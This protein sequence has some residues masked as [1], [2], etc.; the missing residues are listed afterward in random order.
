MMQSRQIVKHE[1]HDT[2]TFHSMNTIFFIQLPVE[3]MRKYSTMLVE[4]LQHIDKEWSRFT[5]DNELARINQQKIGQV[6][7]ISPL[8]YECLQQAQHYYEQTAGAFSPYLKQAMCAHGYDQPFPFTQTIA[9]EQVVSK[10][11]SP[12]IFLSEFRLKRV[13]MGEIDLG[14]FA[15]GFI[16]EKLA[17]FLQQQ[18]VQDGMIDGGGDIRV[19]SGGYKTWKLAV[20]DPYHQQAPPLTTITLQNG[21]AATSN[22]V[23]R[24]W[25]QGGKLKHHLLDG[26][27][28]KVCQSNIVQVT[29][30]T[31]RLT[32]A[33]VATK[34]C[35]LQQPLPFTGKVATYIVN[36]QQQAQWQLIG[37]EQ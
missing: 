33:E 24:S 23:Y 34:L 2:L 11:Q 13:A 21:A 30:V 17:T 35:F 18:G 37:K 16:I 12:F 14:G 32:E 36:D 19:W 10:Q 20:A 3:A 6:V 5:S 28:G 8:L 31:A 26:R 29:V 4:Q 1:E 7:A 25:S 15:K 22:R 9:T 27:T